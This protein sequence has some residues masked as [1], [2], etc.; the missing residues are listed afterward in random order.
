MAL[1]TETTHKPRIIEI[2]GRDGKQQPYLGAHEAI[3][4][5]RADFPAPRSAIIPLVNLETKIVRAEIYIDGTLVSCA[6]VM[7]TDSSGK[8]LEKLETAAIRRALAFLGYGTV[9][10]LAAE[11]DGNSENEAGTQAKVA[12][13]RQKL[14]TDKARKNLGSGTKDRRSIADEQP[15]QDETE[16]E[17]GDEP[18]AEATEG[19]GLSWDDRGIMDK[20]LAAAQELLDKPDLSLIEMSKYAGMTNNIGVVA[21]WSHKYPTPDVALADIKDQFDF[22][23]FA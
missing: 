21:K 9:G 14:D 3:T 7:N 20:L 19:N 6:D 12:Q 2:K 13:A 17:S 22:E 15:A 11:A 16:D 18:T 10:A 8:S 1:N 23:R 4:W 5:F